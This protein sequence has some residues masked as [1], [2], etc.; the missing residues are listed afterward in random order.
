MTINSVDMDKALSSASYA[1][2]VLRSGNISAEQKGQLSA[3]W[4]AEN[5]NKWL[6]VDSTQYQIDDA[7]YDAAKEAG[8][9]A[10]IDTTGHDGS[11]TS[12]ASV[13]FDTGASVA[14]AVGTGMLIAG[15]GKATQQVSLATAKEGSKLTEAKGSTKTGAYIAAISAIAVALKYQI[16]KPNEEQY[17]A[18]MELHNQNGE[19]ANLLGEGSNSLTIAQNNMNEAN[20]EVTQLT[21]EAEETNEEA[22]D[23]IEENKTL[24]DFYRQQYENLKAR[25]EAG[26]QLT[27]DER[28]LMK[29]LAPL[30]EDLGEE[31]NV[32][33]EETSE[34]VND[35]NDEIADYQE[36]YDESAETMAE[37]EGITEYAESFDEDTR[38]KCYVEGGSQAL[39]ALSGAMASAKLF[40]GPWWQYILAGAAGV[41]AAR[42]S[43]ASAEQF[44]EASDIK[45]EIH[46]REGVQEYNAETNTMYEEELDNYAGNID[47]IEDLELEVPNDL[48]VP[49]DAETIAATTNTS[50]SGL[51]SETANT[52]E[53]DKSSNNDDKNKKEKDDKQ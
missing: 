8:K 13:A 30:M 15:G 11:K 43:L 19:G 22:N 31:I 53:T 34:T 26:E 3:K 38:T 14:G 42:S 24:F 9:Q 21:E 36:V 2:Q 49:Q 41:A 5:I 6:S 51:S 25:K 48:K 12:T 45:E 47:V 18:A 46:F 35:Y 23:K 16:E 52:Q 29:Q 20:E 17:K 50:E 10:A 28:E 32:T 44:G 7:S 40:A 37:V 1:Q 27:P 33:T 4:G 39:N